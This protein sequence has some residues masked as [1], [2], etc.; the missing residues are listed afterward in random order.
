[1]GLSPEKRDEIA[2]LI[3][4]ALAV[5]CVVGLAVMLQG[6]YTTQKPDKALERERLRIRAVLGAPTNALPSSQPKNDTEK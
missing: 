3:G 6:T 1:M 2:S 4:S 5:T